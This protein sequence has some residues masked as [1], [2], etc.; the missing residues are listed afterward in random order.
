MIAAHSALSRSP[1]LRCVA[2]ENWRIGVDL[3][4]EE[5]QPVRRLGVGRVDVEDAAAT[6]EL[7]GQLDGLGVLVAV[8][9]E[10]GGQFFQVGRLAASQRRDGRRRTR[11]GRGPA[12]TGPGWWSAAGAA[13]RRR[14][15][16]LRRR[17]RWPAISSNARPAAG[18]SSQAGKIAG[19]TPEKVNRSP[20]QPSRSRGWAMTTSER[21]RGVRRQGR[22]GQAGGRTPG[23][24]DDAAAALAQGGQQRL[25]TLG[26]LKKGGQVGETVQSESGGARHGMILPVHFSAAGRFF[27]RE[28]AR[29]RRKP[30]GAAFRR[31]RCHAPAGLRRPLA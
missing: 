30:A 27:L 12:A 31:R 4:A 5:L 25:E 19:R 15:S 9:H 6:A 28:L 10:P 7:A 16:C 18:W 26:G 2:G 13:G 22:G 1:R 24:V 3:V 23:A 21:V 17:S 14:S 8:A 20:A 11:R 29:G